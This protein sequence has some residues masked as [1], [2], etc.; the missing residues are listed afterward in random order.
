MSDLFPQPKSIQQA[1]RMARRW[2]SAQQILL[3]GYTFER[4]DEVGMTAVCKPG[5]FYAAY[6]ICDRPE[7]VAPRGGC[8]CPDYDKYGDFC[9]GVYRH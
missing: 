6:W 8:S 7:L 1:H 9:T 4:D 3:D 2:E 5:S